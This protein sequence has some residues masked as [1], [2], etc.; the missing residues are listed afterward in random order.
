MSNLEFEV[1][2]DLYHAGKTEDGRD[3]EAE[4][5]YIV[6]THPNGDRWM[7]NAVFHGCVAHVCTDPED[8]GMT[9]F[10]DVRDAARAKAAKLL[11]RIEAR[12]GRV[13]LSKHWTPMRPMYGSNAYQQY[14]QFDDWMEEQLE[15]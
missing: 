14:G 8:Y 6:A 1:A 12:G 15:R 3:Y 7:H 11:A 2:C 9:H 13:A 4:L 5:Y 10:E